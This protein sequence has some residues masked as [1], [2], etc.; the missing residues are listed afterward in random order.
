MKKLFLTLSLVLMLVFAFAACDSGDN[1]GDTPH[2]HAYGEWETTKEA[3][4]TEEGT[5]VRRCSCLEQETETIPATGHSFG[6]WVVVKEPTNTEAGKKVRICFC[7]VQE[8]ETI[9]ATPGTE[10][11]S[12]VFDQ[13]ELAKSYLKSEASCTRAAEYY[14]SCTCGEKS[15]ST[16][17]SGSTLQHTFDQKSTKITYLQ[18]NATCTDLAKYYYSCACGAKGTSTFESG[19][20]APHAYNQQNTSEA[21]L[22]S[23]A[24]VDSPAVYYY[25]CACGEKGTNTFFHGDAL[26]NTLTITYAPTSDY[27]FYVVTGVTGQGSVLEIPR[28][29]DGLRVIAIADNAFRGNTTL[30]KVVLPN[31]IE[32]VGANAFRGCTALTDI[33]LPE[34]SVSYLGAYAFAECTSLATIR[35]PSKVATLSEGIFQGCTNLTDVTL[36]DGLK[37]VGNLAFDGCTA[38]SDITLPDT[39]TLLGNMS[40]RHAEALTSVKFST[41]LTAIGNAAFQYCKSLATVEL[42]DKITVIGNSAFSYCYGLKEL[43]ILGKIAS[44]GNSTFYEC[45]G[46]EYIYIEQSSS[47]SV[48][49]Q[50]YIFYNA[51]TVGDGIAFSYKCNVTLPDLLFTPN[52]DKN[53]PKIA[54]RTALHNYATTWTSDDTDHW[55]ACQN[56]GCASRLDN[57][58]HAFGGWI[59]DAAA[60]CQKTGTRHHVCTVCNKSVSETIPVNPTAH[61]YATAWTSDNNNHWH[62][63]QNSGCTSVTDKTEHTWDE[64]NTCAVCQKYKDDGVK[65]TKQSDGTYS[66]T[67]Y[68]GTATEVIIPSAY[69]GC[70]VTSIGYQAFYNCRSLTSIT[71]GEN[72]KLTSIGSYAFN[73]CESLTSITIPSSVTSIGNYAFAYC[74]SLNAV[75]ISD[76]AAWCKIS[77]G[78]YMANPLY[79]A[80]KLYLRDQ[81]VTDL[82]IPDSVTSIGDYAFRNCESLTSITIGNGVTTISNFAFDGC[83]SLTSITIPSSVTSIGEY[84]FFGCT[85]L[86]S[87]TIPDSVTSI[88][89]DAFRACTS[90][91]S[92]TFGGTKAQW[93]SV[94]KGGDW[95]Y[96]TPTITVKC[97]DG[98]IT[99]KY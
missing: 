80:R 81:L 74:K 53:L 72:S 26:V 49:A 71:F 99:V 58:P 7:G 42:H 98:N 52:D 32:N 35:I 44:W 39:V 85:S 93:Q 56:S 18:S 95:N 29:Y 10:T 88:G 17:L 27:S 75:Y 41:G 28:I 47:A 40:F 57:S 60:T 23:E 94:S 38:L 87:I 78:G 68:T 13:K 24:T 20:V 51:G 82:G 91:T 83:S 96:D 12:H 66:V 37:T 97:T 43:R 67:D 70:A 89:D 21:Y 54:S 4:C 86:T 14:Y 50:N 15:D 9:P 62:K 1:G 30:T 34:E 46:L 33:N 59:V 77:F 84:A 8:S 16:F 11:H 3:S 65:F 92:I 76:I 19:S 31:T 2:T 69:N 36:V 48:G 63:C 55:Y 90:L 79:Y 6:A 22:K 5:K 25:S 73:D 45:T 61:N 64:E